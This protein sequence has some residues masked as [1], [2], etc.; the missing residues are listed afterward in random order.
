M[1]ARL[2]QESFTTKISALVLPKQHKASRQVNTIGSL[3][4]L[5]D[6]LIKIGTPVI[7]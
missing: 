4:S 7:L 6:V 5:N 3:L 2:N 1:S